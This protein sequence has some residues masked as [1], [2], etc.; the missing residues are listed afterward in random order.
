MSW[1]FNVII[2]PLFWTVEAPVVFPV[3]N[4]HKLHDVIWGIHYCTLHTVPIISCLTNTY[5]TKNMTMVGEDWRI[6]FVAGLIYIYAN[7]L[8][9]QVEGAPMYPYADWK[10]VPLTIFLYFLLGCTQT[11]AYIGIQRY[12]NHLRPKKEPTVAKSKQITYIPVVV[13]QK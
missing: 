11:G 1:S 9:T 2:C 8:G 6:M 13:V 7:W 10:N 3:L 12:I 4:L 5:L